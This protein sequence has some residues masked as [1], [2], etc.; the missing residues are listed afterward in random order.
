MW[1]G[2]DV[3]AVAGVSAA[4][5]L[6]L[7]AD[8]IA[9]MIALTTWDLRILLIAA[10]AASLTFSAFRIAKIAKL[11]GRS[12]WVWFFIS[13]FLTALPATIVFWHDR[14]KGVSAGYA[15][16]NN[17]NDDRLA[18]DPPTVGRCPHCGEI[19]DAADRAA[20]QCPHCNMTL[21]EGHYA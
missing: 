2:R 12:P 1:L 18:D 14:A 9:G 15:D 6:S 17:E 8:K 13:L 20:G 19:L 21:D 4:F 10:L 11:L 5:L 3:L 7:P 16:N